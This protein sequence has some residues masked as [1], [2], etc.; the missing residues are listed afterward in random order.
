VIDDHY[1]SE[2]EAECARTEG[3]ETWK[4]IQSGLKF[5]LFSQLPE[6]AILQLEIEAASAGDRAGLVVG[7]RQF[8]IVI[9]DVINLRMISLS[10]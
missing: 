9:N 5:E 6:P 8:A 3:C 4:I 10:S 7:S 2:R 1:S